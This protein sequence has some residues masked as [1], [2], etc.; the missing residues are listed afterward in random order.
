MPQNMC[1]LL[2]NILVLILRLGLVDASEMSIQP[3]IHEELATF[4][5]TQIIVQILIQIL[6]G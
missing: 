1:D 4:I 5:S 2:F 6:N 3:A